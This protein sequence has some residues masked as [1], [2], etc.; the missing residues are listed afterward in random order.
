[1]ARGDLA[2]DKK[3]SRIDWSIIFDLIASE[4][5]YTWEQFTGMTYK[6]LDAC[7]EAIHRRTHN[8]TA[9]L[10]QM[11]GIKMELYEKRQKIA[12]PSEKTL[13]AV[14]KHISDIL[15]EKQ[16]QAKNKA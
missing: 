5:G 8:K 15:K 12:P 4:Y 10:A 2:G 9:V 1:M 13:K 3:A 7:L 6:I 16:K 11:H 14:D